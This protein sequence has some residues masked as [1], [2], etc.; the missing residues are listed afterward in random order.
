M[1]PL[2]SLSDVRLTSYE[3]AFLVGDLLTN[4]ITFL[5][6]EPKAGK[7]ALAAGIVIALLNGDESFL[8]QP[9]YRSVRRV[10][11]GLTDDGADEELRARLDGAVPDGAVSVF[12]IEQ[13]TRGSAT[14]WTEVRDMLVEQDADLFVLDNVLGALS[15][16]EDISSSVV[17]GQI[18]ENL[19][20]I[21]AKGIPVLAVTHTPKGNGEGL[22][23]ASSVIGGRA[24]AAGSRGVVAL[25]VSAKNG[26]RILTRM[27]RGRED[28]D[29]AVRL[30][31]RGPGSEVPVWTLESGQ[32][33][34]VASGP[35]NDTRLAA[36]AEHLIEKQ[37]AEATSVRAVAQRFG[38]EFDLSPNMIQRRLR[39]RAT[40]NDGRWT[41]ADAP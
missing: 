4:R 9:V 32:R 23:V 15:S 13:P 28:L 16:S 6:G 17:A 24:I 37:P 18:A 19:R 27:N 2:R 41:A 7:S 25:R 38:T 31:T 34:A 20:G 3:D 12:Q 35:S 11:F 26:R 36:L 10:V 8:G 40:F 33:A 30:S 29:L 39:E 5:T 14:Y 1:I 22:T 21:S